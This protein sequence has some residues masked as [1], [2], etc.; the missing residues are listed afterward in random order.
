[1]ISMLDRKKGVKTHEIKKLFIPPMDIYTFQNGTRVCEINLGSQDVFKMEII[2]IAGRSTEDQ[3]LISRATAMLMREGCADKSSAMI[4][5]EID[6]YGSSIKSASNMDFSYSTLYSLLRHADKGIRLLHEIYTSPTFPEQEIEKFKKLSI[7][8]LKEELSKNEVLTYRHITEE[9]FGENHA[10]G[11][12][13]TESDYNNINRDAIINHFSES[14]GSD[15]CIIILSGKI[16]DHIRNEVSRYF[17][18]DYKAAKKTVNV[19]ATASEVGRKINIT[20]NNE[21]QSAIKTGFRLFDKN[22]PDH[23]AFFLTNTILGGYFG[24]RLMTKIREELGYTYDIYSNMDQMLYDGCFYVSTETTPEYI[25]PVFQEIY[26]QMEIM[27]QEPI[28][29]QELRMVKNYLMGSFMNILDGPFNVSSFVKTMLLIGKE[30]NDFLTF[31]DEILAMQQE[32]IM[33]MA[34]KYFLKEKMIEIVVSH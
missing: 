27:K 20:S 25:A 30:P 9:V 14:Y 15:N 5:E 12:N 29:A 26:H 34:Q 13:S 3:K 18:N 32:K 17:G 6:Y 33:E 22:H 31:T 16:T 21:H 10:Y 1:M 23:A 19:P 7:Q 24:S 8:K 28:S 4:A 11:Y 2:H